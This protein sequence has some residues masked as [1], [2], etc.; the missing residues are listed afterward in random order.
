V[1]SV[2]NVGSPSDS[3]LN[4]PSSPS[5]GGRPSSGFSYPQPQLYQRPAAGLGLGSIVGYA[6]G[7][8]G[9]LVALFVLLFMRH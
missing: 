2:S 7:A 1:S 6:I 5:T 8:L 4:L 3:S 9:L